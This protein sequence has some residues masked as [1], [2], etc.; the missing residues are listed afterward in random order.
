VHFRS[1][2]LRKTKILAASLQ[3][4]E[5]ESW[6][7]SVFSQTHRVDRELNGHDDRSILPP[8]RVVAHSGSWA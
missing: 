7:I 1:G 4:P 2:G 6:V 5:F 3:Y 8:Y